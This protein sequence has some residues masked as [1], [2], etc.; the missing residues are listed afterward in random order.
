MGP[1]KYNQGSEELTEF[2]VFFSNA[3]PLDIE[4]YE[5]HKSKISTDTKLYHSYIYILADIKNANL[6]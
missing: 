6:A 1:F 5:Y 2:I 4:E 3:N